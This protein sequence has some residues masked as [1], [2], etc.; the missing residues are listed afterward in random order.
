MWT[1]RRLRYVIDEAAQAFG[2]F[3]ESTRT[4]IEQN[5]DGFAQEHPYG[6]ILYAGLSPTRLLFARTARPQGLSIVYKS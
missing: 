4:I 5:Y 1:R 3:P 6:G 2:F